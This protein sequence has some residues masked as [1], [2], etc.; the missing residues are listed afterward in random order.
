MTIPNKINHKGKTIRNSIYDKV[1]PKRF[2]V[3]NNNE[4]YIISD[5]K[6][7]SNKDISKKKVTAKSFEF[8]LFKKDI[9]VPDGTFQL[10]KDK[11]EKIDVEEGI[12]NWL[13]NQTTWKIGYVDPMAKAD[14]GFYDETK[15]I[16]MYEPLVIKN[17]QRD[18]VLYD[19][20][21]NIDI[22]N[23]ALKFS[24]KYSNI[25]S[26][27]NKNNNLY[28]EE[29]YEHEFDKFGQPIVNIKASYGIDDDYKCIIKYE[30]KLKDGF[31]KKIKKEFTYLENLDVNIKSIYLTYN[32]GNK[33]VRTKTKYRSFDRGIH[34]WLPFL[35]DILST[36]FD[37]IF[38]FDTYN[39][40]IN[41]CSRDNLGRDSGFY[42][43]YD[44]YMQDIERDLKV[45]EV[46]TRLVV[47]GKDGK[48][49][50]EVNPLGTNYIED[51]TYLIK[52]GNVSNELQTALIRYERL[53]KIIYEEWNKLKQEKDSKYK[54]S[55]Y[56][57][58]QLSDL[59]E[60]KKVQ[61]AL[62][63]AYIK[64]GEEKS[65]LAAEDYNKIDCEILKILKSIATIMKDL[66]KLKDEIR[67]LDAKMQEC[68]KKIIKKDAK[69]SEGYIFTSE[70]LNELDEFIY[71][72][73][74]QDDY[75]TDAD[76]LYRNGKLVLKERN[77][78][79]I[80][81]KSNVAGLTKHPRGW[82]NILGLGNKA[83]IV[84][85]DGNEDVED[86]VVI[87]TGFKYIPP[88]NES[89]HCKIE[90]VEF[91]NK[92][93]KYHDLKSIRN[94]ARKADYSKNAVAFWKS[95]WID[96][97]STNMV[98][99]D[100]RTKG[101]DTSKV[102]ITSSSSV[103]QTDIT[104]SGM[105]CTDKSNGNNDNQMYIGSGF[106]SVTNDN[107]NNCKVIADEKGVVA[108]SIVGTGIIGERM[109]LANPENTFKIDKNGLSIYD[110]NKILKARL[111]FYESC[112]KTMCSFLMYD[113][114][115]RVMINGDGM[116]Q[117]D[118]IPKSD[119]LDKDHSMFMYV[120]IPSN[121]KEVR[122]ANLFI[123]LDQYRS[124]SKGIG[125]ENGELTLIT[126]TEINGTNYFN[127]SNNENNDFDTSGDIAKLTNDLRGNIT[128]N[129][130]ENNSHNHIV[131][132]G[133][134]INNQMYAI[135]ETTLPKNIKIIVNGKKVA[136]K[137]N[138]DTEI[139]IKEFLDLN[140][141]NIIEFRSDTNGRIDA[142][143]T[144]NEFVS[145]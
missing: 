18:T 113:S 124:Y 2:I 39:K 83:H 98:I 90:S 27:D 57:E 48:S 20:P 84:Y 122:E 66:T 86:G 71:S 81:F 60:K 79:P 132:I 6:I 77:K 92:L 95:T 118:S 133:D 34:Q 136:D 17:V 69:D 54:E 91:E 16:K 103:N 93:K 11:N 114:K 119:S 53:T 105:W 24:I 13:E 74:Q 35:R 65:E 85:E 126:S 82:K 109:N 37:C 87:V 102:A 52:Q 51:F 4:R 73:R 33:V 23:K 131:K 80:S 68:N 45:D 49:I 112:G 116:A 1:K 145:I 78:I 28:K 96:S 56:L 9:S 42:L 134:Y 61:D 104:N 88:K 138:E 141:L 97:T 22:G 50:N 29:N 36:A 46:I 76:E 106:I 55:L 120:N 5:I 12:L 127:L 123:H 14:T 59:N 142:L 67:T 10:Y 140:K 139:N 115:G 99:R 30:F 8:D 108:R 111:G 89:D 7:E 3:I 44:Q 31:I 110:N 125:D 130:F 26:T 128:T 107:W 72:E 117:I 137:I 40:I 21:V 62:K 38:E 121:V 135:V 43:Y 19:K 94:V 58:A 63:V 41:V 101:I 100:I 143:L 32:T 15:D 70:D 129:I 144:L 47:E 64:A 25:K 75:Y